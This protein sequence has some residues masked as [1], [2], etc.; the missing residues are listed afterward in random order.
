MLIKTISQ[1]KIDK[2]KE[3]IDNS[4]KIAI[5]AHIDPDGDA[6]GSS[7]SLRRSLEKYGKIA[8]V[9]KLSEIDDYLK[10]LPEI[11]NYKDLSYDKYD[12][13]IILD[14]SEFDRIDK[15]YK[16]VEKSKNTIVI[17][18]HTGGKISADLNIINSKSPATCE[19]LFEIMERLNLPMD[20]IIAS[21]IYTGLVT[22][23]GRFLYSNISENT[24]K[25]AG[26]L[27]SYGARTQEIY[28]NL[29]QNKPI[30]KMKFETEVLSQAKIF[31]NIAFASISAD[32]CKK[33]D[34]QIGDSESIVNML[35]DLE[36]I[37]LACI[38]KEYGPK[39]FKISLRSKEYI[40]VS[41]I[42]RNNGGGGHVRAAGFTINADNIEDANA[43]I[44]EILKSVK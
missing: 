3:L 35:R 30:K 21:L 26:K 2:F 23:T 40:D 28:K 36:T 15:A 17:D 25:I 44:E 14:C 34:V 42:A 38:L 1:E 11:E 39:E 6:L 4:Q 41:E 19:L 9:I 5:S 27:F 37:E 31:K 22:D 16:Y 20:E 18:H 29:Y 13:F 7:L 8:E 10:F 43:K 12:L 32:L 33:F 24:F